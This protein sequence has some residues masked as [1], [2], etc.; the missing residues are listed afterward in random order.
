MSNLSNLK[1]GDAVTI[2]DGDGFGIPGVSRS[3]VL[4]ITKGGN[5]RLKGSDALWNDRGRQRGAG[6]WSHVY[7]EPFDQ[8]TWDDLKARHQ[9]KR[10]RNKLVNTDF[11]NLPIET[12]HELLDVLAQEQSRVASE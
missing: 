1:V 9:E 4:E 6:S 3:E 11:K 7:F 5:F 2:F 8:K 10:D 12:V